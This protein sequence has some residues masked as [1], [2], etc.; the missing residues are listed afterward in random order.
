MGHE[1]AVVAPG[2]HLGQERQSGAVATT[3]VGTP[4]DIDDVGHVRRLD[5][6]D[7][8]FEAVE[9]EIVLGPDGQLDP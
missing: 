6:C 2:S 3:N 5:G 1:W 9:V 7:D 8:T 4:N